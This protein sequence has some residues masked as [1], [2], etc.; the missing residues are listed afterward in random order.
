MDLKSTE[1][2]GMDCVHISPA[3]DQWQASF[4]N[5]NEPSVSVNSCEFLECLSKRS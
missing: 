3:T 5:G 1:L 2:L 4:E